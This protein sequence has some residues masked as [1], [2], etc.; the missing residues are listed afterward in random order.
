[1]TERSGG[2]YETAAFSL[3]VIVISVS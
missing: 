3:L 2:E 1:V